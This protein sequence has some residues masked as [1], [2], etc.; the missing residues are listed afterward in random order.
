MM[1]S[2]NV[3]SLWCRNHGSGDARPVDGLSGEL[4]VYPSDLL[5]PCGLSC[6]AL[7]CFGSRADDPYIIYGDDDHLVSVVS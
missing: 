7:L 6:L 5:L 2:E 4:L 3:M 1:V